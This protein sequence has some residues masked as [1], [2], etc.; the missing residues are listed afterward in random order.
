MANYATPE[1]VM[2]YFGYSSWTA[3]FKDWHRLSTKDKYHL[4]RD[5]GSLAG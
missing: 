4:M 5:I 3:F 2:N 1:D